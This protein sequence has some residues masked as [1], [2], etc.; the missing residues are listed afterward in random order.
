MEKKL[1]GKKIVFHTSCVITQRVNNSAS[2]PQ[3][4]PQ[5]CWNWVLQSSSKQKH[6]KYGVGLK[7]N[8]G[9]R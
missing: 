2:N 4:T 1:R 7:A 6:Q 3:S 5:C 8:K 9:Y